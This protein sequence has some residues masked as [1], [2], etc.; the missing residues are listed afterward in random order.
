MKTIQQQQAKY[1]FFSTSKTQKDIAQKVGVAEKT[2]NRWIKQEAWDE[3]KKAALAAPA[4]IVNHLY[5]QVVELQNHIACREP[6]NRFPT[7]QEAEITRKL[8]NSISKLGMGQSLSNQVQV[9]KSFAGY[10]GDTDSEFAEK[11]TDYFVDYT[12][13][14]DKD[15]YYPHEFLY[16]VKAPKADPEIIQGIKEDVEK[17]VSR[18][19][20]RFFHGD[21]GWEQT[22]IPFTKLKWDDIPHHDPPTLPDSKLMWIGNG[23]LFDL[24]QGTR[25]KM[26]SDEANTFYE[27]G[28]DVEWE[29]YDQSGVSELPENNKMSVTNSNAQTDISN[30]SPSEIHYHK[31][32][33]L[34]STANA[35]LHSTDISGHN[36][37]YSTTNNEAPEVYEIPEE[38]VNW[39]PEVPLLP[40][41]I[42]WIGRGRVY[43]IPNNQ[44]RDMMYTEALQ[45][46]E[47]GFDKVKLR[48][49]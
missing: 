3:L 25:R 33:E 46:Q 44:S 16:N 1:F 30:T 49:G 37:P 8:I 22:G 19:N 29:K 27:V 40:G 7:I 4:I 17:S 20:Y 38:L 15:G 10:M 24:E 2:V 13:S 21:P 6:G 18:Y 5:S 36:V 23:Q 26:T 43:D 41:G 42:K 39:W 14:H 47:L 32:I 11:F 34:Q 48:W 28:F 12:R 31:G 9:M 35:N 45:F